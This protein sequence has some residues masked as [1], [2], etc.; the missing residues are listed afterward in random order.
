MTFLVSVVAV[1]TFVRCRAMDCQTTRLN[2]LVTRAAAGDALARSELVGLLQPEASAHVRSL[3]RSHRANVEADDVLNEI[4]RDLLEN[5]DKFDTADF[6]L[7][8]AARRV[9]RFSDF[10]RRQ[11]RT[12]GREAAYSEV[13]NQPSDSPFPGSGNVHQQV[14]AREI[15]DLINALPQRQ[16]A[17]LRLFHFHGCTHEEIAAKLDIRTES[18]SKIHARARKKLRKLCGEELF[19]G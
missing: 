2:G 4:W 1:S 17:V 8:F 15:L 13:D 6:R 9:W 5:L 3:V 12:T 18:V 10:L 11:N 19:S 14:A 7:W 16:R